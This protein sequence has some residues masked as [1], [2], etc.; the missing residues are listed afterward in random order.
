[1]KIEEI[2]ASAIGMPASN[3]L[4]Y[5]AVLPATNELGRSICGM[6]NTEGGLYIIG[7]Q[8]KNRQ[9]IPRGISPD[10]QVSLVLENAL[11]NMGPIVVDIKHGEVQYQE[12]RLYAI[13]VSKS[14]QPVA[15]CNEVYHML[16]GQPIKRVTVDI[17]SPAEMS[18]NEKLDTVLKYLC[19]NKERNNTNANAIRTLIFGDSISLNDAETLLYKLRS[20]GQVRN[21][22]ERFIMYRLGL[23]D[24][25]QQGGFSAISAATGITA[26]PPVTTVFI[27]YNWKTK[28]AAQRLGTLLIKQGFKVSMDDWELSYKD[29]LPAFMESICTHDFAVLFISDKYLKSVNCMNEVLH[30]MKEQNSREKI[31]PILDDNVELFTP[32]GR[33]QYI[34]YWAD[35]LKRQTELTEGIDP[36]NAIEEFKILRQSRTISQDIGD[37]L[38]LLSRMVLRRISPLDIAD[39][40][41]IIDYMKK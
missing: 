4:Q 40:S 16:H 11:K 28:S 10:F 23:E 1:M 7:V 22:G 21:I 27:S 13:S 8:N 30:A 38:V 36:L 41:E 37:F 6:A 32:A 24:F 29:D 39:Y 9:I 5:A 14:G 25:L 15:Y 31:I 18:L 20:S 2:V 26:L 3:R 35:H 33:V 17:K 12:K 34:N 19:N